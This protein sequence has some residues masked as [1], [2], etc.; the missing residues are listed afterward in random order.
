MTAR[1]VAG[2]NGNGLTVRCQRERRMKCY[3]SG[4]SARSGY[5]VGVVVVVLCYD[6]NGNDDKCRVANGK[7]ANK[8]GQQWVLWDVK[9]NVWSNAQHLVSA[10]GMCLWGMGHGSAMTNAATVSS[11]NLVSRCMRVICVG[12]MAITMGRV[13]DRMF[14]MSTMGL[15]V[16]GLGMC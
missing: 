16:G 9:S 3:G 6:S 11:A 4:M 7:C 5:G 8:W 2:S 13:N 12:L 10:N 14:A 15:W 1:R